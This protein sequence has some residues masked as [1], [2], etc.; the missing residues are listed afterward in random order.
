MNQ[1]E[2]K[3]TISCFSYGK[4]NGQHKRDVF[5]LVGDGPEC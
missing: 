4:K 3:M 5:I 1:K 2:Q